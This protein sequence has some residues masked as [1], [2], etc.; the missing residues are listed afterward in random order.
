M[1][2][3]IRHAMDLHRQ[4]L[5]IDG[6]NDLP[7]QYELMADRILSRIDI[8]ERQP[9]LQTDIPRLRE[10]R[11]GGQFWGVFVTPALK[12]EEI[13]RAT[14]QQFDLAH[15][16]IDRYPETFQLALTADQVEQAFR[17]GKIASILS[18]EGGHSIDDSLA[19]LRM[20][21]G[22]GAHYMTLTHFKT[23]SWADSAT[24]H[25]RSNG[26]S[27]FGREVV[28]EM[29]RLGMMVDLSHVS[30]ETMHDALDIAQ[31]P[32]IFSHSSARALTDN[33][34]N[35]PDDVLRRIPENGGVVMASFVPFFNSEAASAQFIDLEREEERLES[36][37]DADERSVAE[38]IARWEETNPTPQ[39]KLTDV[40]DHIDHIRNVV[41]VDHVGIGSDFDGI[42]Y[43]PDGL[44]DVS[45]YPALTAELIRRDYGDQD[46][47]KIMG[48][49]IIR[50]MRSA[51]SVARDLKGKRGPSE[52]LIEELDG[53]RASG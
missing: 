12:R 36:L 31:A 45:K 9:E 10:G 43:G 30:T 32:L 23:I 29:N 14:I 18:L 35:V 41:G 19:V 7:W 47:I 11:V 20:F 1:D 34:R 21:Y 44:E 13:V 15:N 17:A 42:T 40:A 39:V 28:R 3:L 25:P 38:G 8:G 53:A 48:Q 22:L 37:P 51:E 16:L 6:H 49:N 52:A 46:I 27:A 5:L 26:L 33:P 2:D 50:V 24:D 4:A